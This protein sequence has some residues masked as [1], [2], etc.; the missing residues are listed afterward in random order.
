MMMMMIVLYCIV[1][2]LMLNSAMLH[3]HKQCCKW[4]VHIST[5]SHTNYVYVSQWY[6][7]VFIEAHEKKVYQ[8]NPLHTAVPISNFPN[9]FNSFNQRVTVSLSF[10]YML[11]K[12]ICSS[13]LAQLVKLGLVHS[14]SLWFSLSFLSQCLHISGIVPLK[15]TP[16]SNM[17][18]VVGRLF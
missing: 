12:S 6:R 15:F 9:T 18:K 7:L 16:H 10:E 8:L 13:L 2:Y 5:R 17:L 4:A 14:F 11:Q 3:F 1:L